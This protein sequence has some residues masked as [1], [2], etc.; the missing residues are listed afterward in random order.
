MPTELR[1]LIFSRDELAEAIANYNGAATNGVPAGRIMFCKVT[2]NSG[3]FVTVKIVPEGET[4]V[5]TVH[6]DKNTVG[7]A[8]MKY[9]LDKNI[10]MPKK[11]S[12]TLQAIGDNI[13]MSLCIDSTS[14]ELPSFV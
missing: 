3:I 1:Q 8:L 12:K 5:H 13:A 7:A 10:P 14:E 6:L 4:E 2:Q 9:C 11:A